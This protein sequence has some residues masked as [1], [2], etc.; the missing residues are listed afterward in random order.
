MDPMSETV[1][2]I[3]PV[4][5]A[6]EAAQSKKAFDIVLLDLREVT[7]FTDYFLI[8][9]ASSG[10]QAQ[11]I[12]DEISR[13]LSLEGQHASHVEGYNL[14]DWILMDYVNFV[15]HVFSEQARAFYSLE[16]LWRTAKRHSI[17]AE[18]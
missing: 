17:A 6:V 12:C 9:S 5:E 4:M 8:C 10:R 15:V 13:R 3:S 16:R 18:S 14:A 7:T 11:A 2:L 1:E